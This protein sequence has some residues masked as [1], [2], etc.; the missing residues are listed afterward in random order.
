MLFGNGGEDPLN[1]YPA[2]VL[3]IG[4]QGLP[5]EIV[6]PQLSA[7]DVHL[8]FHPVKLG[9]RISHHLVS[10]HGRVEF[11]FQFSS[12]FFRTNSP[13][14]MRA[15]QQVFFEKGLVILQASDDGSGCGFE[16]G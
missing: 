8:A 4:R 6:A 12:E 1:R 13:I 2:A 5:W 7:D 9:L 3:V 16:R 14:A 10:A 11:Q 15:R